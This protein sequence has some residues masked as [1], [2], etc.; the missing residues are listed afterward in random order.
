MYTDY[1]TAYFGGA[2][3]TAIMSCLVNGMIS[4]QQIES[5]KYNI[6]RSNEI[7]IDKM[8]IDPAEKLVMKEQ[9]KHTLEAIANGI[10]D[11]LKLGK[12]LISDGL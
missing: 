5:V 1:W 2:F 11:E 6:L 12:K 3:R 10:K 8:A 7:K 4:E 9:C